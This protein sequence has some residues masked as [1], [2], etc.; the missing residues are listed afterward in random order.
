MVLGVIM[1]SGI[2]V[3]GDGGQWECCTLDILICL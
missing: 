1:V 3:G 2:V